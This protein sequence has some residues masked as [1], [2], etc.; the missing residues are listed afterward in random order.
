MTF[1]YNIFGFIQL[2]K[3]SILPFI[4]KK[5]IIFTPINDF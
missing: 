2:F 3:Q 1:N 4:H 5:N